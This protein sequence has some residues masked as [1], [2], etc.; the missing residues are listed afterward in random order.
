MQT[1]ASRDGGGGGGL[2]IAPLPNIPWKCTPIPRNFT[3]PLLS[4]PVNGA[5]EYLRCPQPLK[6]SLLCLSF[7]ACPHLQRH[8][9]VPYAELYALHILSSSIGGFL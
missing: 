2:Y 9:F 1:V 4:L 7:D 8:A 5:L 3:P 6:K